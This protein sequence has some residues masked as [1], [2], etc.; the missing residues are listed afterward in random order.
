MAD[1]EPQGMLPDR[2]SR[3]APK[4]ELSLVVPDAAHLLQL[5]ERAREAEEL[6]GLRKLVAAWQAAAEKC[7]LAFEELTR[8]AVYRLEVERDL[9]AHLAQTVHRGGHRA[10]SP[11]G[12]LL[13]TPAPRLQEAR[14][15]HLGRCTSVR[16]VAGREPNGEPQPQWATAPI[17]G[18]LGG[19][20]ERPR[21]HRESDD[22]GL[23]RRRRR[24][25]GEAAARVHDGT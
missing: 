6:P 16:E 17:E 24:L 13:P 20:V 23:H 18:G 12:A 1:E 3:P 25:A 4:P 8:L 2:P 9:G 5:R 10:K 22:A 11:R 7:D 19:A 14:G 21:L 15:A